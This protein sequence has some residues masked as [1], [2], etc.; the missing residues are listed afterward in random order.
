MS[1]SHGTNEPGRTQAFPARLFARNADG[2]WTLLSHAKNAVPAGTPGWAEKNA[3][4]VLELAAQSFPECGFALVTFEG[5]SEL[6]RKVLCSEGTATAIQGLLENCKW[7]PDWPP[8]GGVVEPANGFRDLVPFTDDLSGS[9]IQAYHLLVIPM[10]GAVRT[11]M[12][13]WRSS[14]YGP[15]RELEKGPLRD[16]AQSL[17]SI[18]RL[19]GELGLSHAIE[20]AQHLDRLRMSFL[21]VDRFQQLQFA[22]DAAQALLEQ[23]TYVHAEDGVLKLYDENSDA[24]L[25]QLMSHIATQPKHSADASGIVAIRAANGDGLARCIVNIHRDTQDSLLGSPLIGLIIC[26]QSQSE[27]LQPVQLRR[28]GFTPAE[29]ELSADLLRGLTVTQHAKERGIAVATARAHLKRA[30]M[31]L[32]VH[33]Q[34]DLIR[35][36]VGLS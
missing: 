3:R 5:D 35:H 12:A 23:G 36:I 8:A 16:R 21:L 11:L 25:H 28:L 19:G 32:G 2:G 14:D 10:A 29:A 30:M 4:A 15:F 17:A 31:R 6:P 1:R 9:G 34:A 27:A 20:L 24:R 18:V 26:A 13:A 22:N 33:R 7:N